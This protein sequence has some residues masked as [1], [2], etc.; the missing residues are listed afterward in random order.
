LTP[1]S[2]S[3]VGHIFAAAPMFLKHRPQILG[4]FSHG[5]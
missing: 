2:S 3:E 4:F 5:E 1:R